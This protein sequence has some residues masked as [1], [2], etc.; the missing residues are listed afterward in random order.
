MRWQ[1]WR[2]QGGLLTSP[3]FVP[4]ALFASLTLA[5]LM[6]A[7]IWS[8]ENENAAVVKSE[9]AALQ[10]GLAAERLELVS[11]AARLARSPDDQ[12]AGTAAAER[13][14]AASIFDEIFIVDLE[15]STA[16]QN[17]RWL[18]A[19]RFPL[20]RSALLPVF[21]RYRERE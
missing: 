20:L 17:G 3:S 18:G 8:C 1:L 4:I 21:A 6:L 10:A 19:D 13:P 7:A 15:A 5:V 11:Q 9:A 14:H 16:R 12:V 2:E